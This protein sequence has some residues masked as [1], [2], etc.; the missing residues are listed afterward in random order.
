MTFCKEMKTILARHKEL[1]S[2]ST[3]FD[4]YRVF[5]GQSSDLIAAT[6]FIAERIANGDSVIILAT[7]SEGNALGFTQ[8]FPAFT[9]VGLAKTYI[10]NDL[11]VDPSARRRGVADLLLTEAAKFARDSGAVRLQLCTAKE[12]LEAKALYTAGGWQPNTAFDY[13]T[14]NL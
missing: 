5:Y 1:N 11:F 8:M 12:N 3:L 7:D 14:L 10:V 13:Y 9:S 6:N 4:A 2:V